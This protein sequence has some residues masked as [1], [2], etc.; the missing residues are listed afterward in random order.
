MLGELA[1]DVFVHHAL[2]H[3]LAR[4]AVEDAVV[5]HRLAHGLEQLL[6]EDAL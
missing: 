3:L 4:P 2:K 1:G 6:D 5:R